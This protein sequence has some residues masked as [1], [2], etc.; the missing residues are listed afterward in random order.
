MANFTQSAS[1]PGLGTAT[2]NIPETSLYSFQGSLTLNDNAGS[3]IQGPGGGAGTGTGAP[4]PIPSQVIVTINQNGSPIFTTNPG[5][6]SFCLNAYGCTAGDVITFVMTSSLAQ[7][8][9]PSSVR[10]TLSVS[11]GPI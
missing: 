8:K 1:Y 3:A 7:D 4:P 5:D 2:V 10:L 6:R 11:E 9:L